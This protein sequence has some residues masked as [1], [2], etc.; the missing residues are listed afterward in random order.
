MEGMTKMERNGRGDGFWKGV[1][2]VLLIVLVA[3]VGLMYFQSQRPT[4][5]YH[6]SKG[7]SITSHLASLVSG[8]NPTDSIYWVSDLAAKSLPYVVNTTTSVK[9]DSKKLAAAEGDDQ[10]QQ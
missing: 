8:G 4:Y 5:V 10:S 6:E 3:V 2:I 9:P 1:S 7:G